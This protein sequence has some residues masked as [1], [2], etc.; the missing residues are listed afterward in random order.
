MRV[1]AG[2]TAVV[3]S[4]LLLVAHAQDGAAGEDA[5]DDPSPRDSGLVE[6]SGTRLAQ[7]DITV[8]GP[9]EVAANLTQEDFWI[10]VQFT[11]VTDFTLDR[12]C[13]GATDGRV[14]AAAPAPVITAGTTP[15]RVGATSSFLFY[16]DQIFLTLGGRQNAITLMRQLIRR[17]IQNGNRGMLVS[18]AK[19][20]I[21][22]Q[23]MTDDAELLLEA[24]ERL[25]HNREQWHEYATLEDARVNR[26]IRMMND[27]RELTA[28]SSAIE[29]AMGLAR[30]YQME[31]TFRA[32][33][34]L[35]R[36]A[37][38]LLRMTDEPSPKAA[39]LFSD[40]LR[41]NAGAHYASFFGERLR[42]GRVALAQI[43][44]DG[45]AANN[46]FDKIV[47]E[48]A[49]QGIRFYPV[50]SQG[51]V[52]AASVALPSARTQNQIQGGHSGS[53]TRYYQARD[54]LS[55]LATETG[56]Y[57]FVNGQSATR[58]AETVQADFACLYIASFDPTG[59]REDHPLRVIIE[60]QRDDITV[61]SRGR[62]VV[63]SASARR[64]S[65]LVNAFASRGEAGDEPLE[66]RANIVPIGFRKGGFTALLQISV[67][68]APL[69]G[70]TWDMGA[71]VI[72]RDKVD[73]EASGRISV[74][75]PGLPVVFEKELS[76]RPGSYEVISVAHEASTGLIS[77]TQ[78]ELDWPDPR[79]EA[80][81]T[82]PV[83][84][85]QP[86]PGA[87][88]R[89]EATRKSGSLARAVEE[90]LS[91]NLP[92]ALVSLVCRGRKHKG[93][94]TVSRTLVGNTEVEFPSVSPDL[95]EESCAQIRDLVPAK[96][97]G[98]GYYRYRVTVMNGDETLHE[99][100]REFF[101]VDPA[102]R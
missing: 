21:V 74:P 50:L 54:S 59:F 85:L 5:S 68:P 93:P 36:L 89:D 76:F 25:E 30:R 11:K 63:Q 19:E 16:T 90:P 31:E 52:N 51:I 48:A 96:T 61:R 26:L 43:E 9:P 65:Q 53:R 22:I 56:G 40:T 72:T 60:S 46:P 58:I 41:Q 18:N 10:R 6:R 102:E 75:L 57:A 13:G 14:P 49:A 71:S 55:N 28:G 15:P 78:S 12:Y 34:S 66:V 37:M 42:T 95:T 84:V 4:G 69:Q 67:P 100:D 101:A 92:T 70:A 39:F 62:L 97:L 98:E 8:M 82:T 99:A 24:V 44:S 79:K 17:L 91:T 32:E 2:L 27:S 86:V 87:F 83:A 3:L 77:S 20:L 35:R 81:T 64:T 73:I 88:L 1:V 45:W 80:I 23:P 94:V 29:R 33:K 7:I 47:N 38:T